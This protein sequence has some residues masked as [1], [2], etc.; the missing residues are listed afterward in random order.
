M[1]WIVYIPVL[2]EDLRLALRAS[3]I[4]HIFQKLKSIW[5]YFHDY[6]ITFVIQTKKLTVTMRNFLEDSPT[7]KKTLG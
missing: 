3:Y 6:K 1:F 4:R 7:P 5:L 2:Q